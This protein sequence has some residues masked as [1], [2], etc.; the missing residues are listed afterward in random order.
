MVKKSSN[1]SGPPKKVYTF[2]NTAYELDIIITI[3]LVQ[4][5]Q[6]LQVSVMC[7]YYFF[8]LRIEW[9]RTNHHLTTIAIHH[10]ET[11][12]TQYIKP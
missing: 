5:A 12:H 6:Y 11:K 7:T 2:E 9:H 4:L 8:R 1:V 10:Q 3:L